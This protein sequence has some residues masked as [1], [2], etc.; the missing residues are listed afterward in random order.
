MFVLQI[1]CSFYGPIQRLYLQY[2]AK[3]YLFSGGTWR[4]VLS[5]RTLRVVQGRRHKHRKTWATQEFLVFYQPTN[6]WLY[7]DALWG[8]KWKLSDPLPDRR[9][10]LHQ[11]ACPPEVNSNVHF[12]LIHSNFMRQP[13]VCLCDCKCLC[14]HFRYACLPAA[15]Q[16]HL[17]SRLSSGP[18]CSSHTSGSL[19]ENQ[20]TVWLAN[21]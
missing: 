16:A 6:L 1:N 15:V 11:M 4:T 21:A 3:G 7:Q 5:R 8:R 12:Q 17:F 2:E 20:T 18:H 13:G 9:F 19:L 14:V 10:S